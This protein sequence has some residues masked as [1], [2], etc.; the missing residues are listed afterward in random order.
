LVWAARQL[1][2]ELSGSQTQVRLLHGDLHHCNVLFDDVRGWLAVDPKG[3]VGELEYGAA[4]RYPYERPELFAE[5]SIVRKRV[6]RFASILNLD[7]TR[8]LS[9]A[10]CS[11]RSRRYLGGRGWHSRLSRT[12]G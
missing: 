10:F 1:F 4:L 11:G 5:P 9:W 6:E 8:V 12:T 2:S 7:T 3:V